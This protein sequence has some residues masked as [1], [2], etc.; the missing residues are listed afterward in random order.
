MNREQQAAYRQIDAATVVKALSPIGDAPTNYAQVRPLASIRDKDGVRPSGSAPGRRYDP[1]PK[2]WLYSR[3]DRHPESGRGRHPGV[4]G[5][6]A[7]SRYLSRI[8]SPI[9]I[10]RCKS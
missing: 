4:R 7:G 3:L 8:C 6:G 10:M 2:A 1:I 5:Q 9:F